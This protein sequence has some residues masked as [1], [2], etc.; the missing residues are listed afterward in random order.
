MLARQSSRFCSQTSLSVGIF[1][2]YRDGLDRN[3]GAAPSKTTDD[4][5]DTQLMAWPHT[6]RPVCPRRSLFPPTPAVAR[7]GVGRPR[8]AL[9]RVLELS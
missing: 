6:S 2:R 4:R 8:Q 9:R 1:P 5:C 3:R 7:L